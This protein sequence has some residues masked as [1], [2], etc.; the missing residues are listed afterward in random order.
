MM[1]IIMII[2][3]ITMIVMVM[4]MI[5][6]IIMGQPGLIAIIVT[7]HNFGTAGP[8]FGPMDPNINILI[9]MGPGHARPGPLLL[10]LP[11]L[12][13]LRRYKLKVWVGL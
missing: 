13:H 10:L 8:I 6:I 9:I 3:P 11:C 12:P 1:I 2:I 4:I 7:A 5:I